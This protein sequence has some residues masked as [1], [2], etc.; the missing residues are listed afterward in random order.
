VFTQDFLS[1][2]DWLILSGA[3]PRR[4][5]QKKKESGKSM[6]EDRMEEE[7]SECLLEPDSKVRLQ[8]QR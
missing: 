8:K 1:F 6:D 7:P 3:D 5:V 2:V 4:T